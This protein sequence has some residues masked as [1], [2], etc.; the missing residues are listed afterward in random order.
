[1]NEIDRREVNEAI[2]A[3]DEA[4]EHLERARQCLNSAGNWGLLDILGGNFVTGLFKHSKMASAEQE[5]ENARWALQ[6]FS[7]ELK[8]VHGFSSIHINDFLS[9]ADFFFD[10][11]VADV[12]V[13]SKI[14][15]AKKQCDDAIRKVQ[16][17][18]EQLVRY[19]A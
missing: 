14:S 2:A 6:R 5:I 19:R 4:L 3:A 1:M 12:L 11:F 9:F 15:N 13:Q 18:R 7:K 16:D 10:G 17:I 8:D